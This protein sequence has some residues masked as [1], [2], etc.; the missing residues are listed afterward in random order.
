M[1][2]TGK[3]QQHN[4]LKAFFRTTGCCHRVFNKYQTPPLV[5]GNKLTKT[6]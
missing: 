6:K 5:T 4:G 3:A 1:A 2:Q